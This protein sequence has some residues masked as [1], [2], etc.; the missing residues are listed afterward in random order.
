MGSGSPDVRTRIGRILD[1]EAAI[2]AG[3][4]DRR[5]RVALRRCIDTCARLA[6]HGSETLVRRVVSV[7]EWLHAPDQT[8]TGSDFERRC[9]SCFQQLRPVLEPLVG[10][11]E[12]PTRDQLAQVFASAGETVQRELLGG[13][14]ADPS[15]DV[16]C[17]N[18]ANCVAESVQRPYL[19]ATLIR[20]EGG[21]A[22]LDRFGLVAPM[23]ELA[24]RYEEVPQTRDETAAEIVRALDGFRARAPWPVTA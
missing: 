10:R 1:A 16:V 21:H 15:F 4:S 23:T 6:D 2:V 18:E 8:R 13:I 19:A 24:T 3:W 14:T 12:E 11:T 7:D 9:L 17:W 20:L 22:P 5:L